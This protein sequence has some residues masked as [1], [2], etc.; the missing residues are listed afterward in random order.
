MRRAV[1]AIG[2]LAL[3]VAFGPPLAGRFLGWGPDRSTLPPPGRSVAIGDGLALNVVEMGNGTPVVLVHGLPSNIGDWAELP[4]ELAE[5]GHRA[6]AYDRVGYGWSSRPAEGADAYTYDSNARQLGE[7]LD[8]LGIGSAALV[9]WSYGGGVVQVF[10]TEHPER[11]SRLVLVGAVGPALAG[12]GEPIERLSRSPI[13]PP[14]F[15]WAMSFAPLA[16]AATRAPLA[17]AFSGEANVPSGFHDRTIAQLAL[18]GT[19]TAWIEEGR[20]SDVSTL[21]PE[22]VS[23]PTLVIQGSDDRSVPR[24]VGEDLARRLPDAD[25]LII[26]GGSH[27]LPV[28]HGDLLADRI[29][30]WLA[31]P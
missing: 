28:T 17:E 18:P 21:H 24:A 30:S 20:R 12:E 7:L 8:A 19:V 3:A 16:R 5:R 6:L 10:A 13:G 23:V 27:M 1:I 25:L 9:G 31:H 11:V 26:E 2:V 29:A 4:R 15:A 14:L 22:R